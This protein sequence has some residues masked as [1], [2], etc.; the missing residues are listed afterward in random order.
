MGANN[1][2]KGHLLRYEGSLRPRGDLL[3]DDV[4][5][6]HSLEQLGDPKWLRVDRLCQ[7]MYSIYA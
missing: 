5:D 7:S 1:Q 3:L 2:H 6:L 4:E